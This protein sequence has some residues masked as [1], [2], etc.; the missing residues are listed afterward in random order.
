MTTTYVPTHP[1]YADEAD[2]RNE[3]TRVF[4]VCQSCRRCIGLCSSFPTLFDMIDARDDHDAGWLTPAQ[5]D[6]V[7]DGCVQC[8]LCSLGCPYTPDRDEASVDFPRLMLRAEAMRYENGHAQP[9]TKSAA[10]VI[11]R[12]DLIGRLATAAAPIANRVVTAEPGSL[13]RKLNAAFTGV[14]SQRL[15][16]TFAHRRFSDWFDDRPRI[17]LRRKQGTVT[18][19]PTCLV[20]YQATGIGSDLV[21][22]YERNGI[23]CRLSD[24]GCCGAPWLHAGDVESFTRV[25]EKNVGRLASEIRRGTDVVVPQPTCSYILKNDYVDYVGTE[26]G[27]DAELVAKRTYDAAEYLMRVHRADDT[28]LDTEFAGIIPD[29]ITYHTPCH[30]RAQKIGYPGRDLLRLTGAQVTLVQQCSGVDG[31]WGLRAGND[32]VAIPMAE[33][34]AEMIERADGDVVVSDCHL[35]NTTIAEQTGLTSVHPLQVV[36]HAYGLTQA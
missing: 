12:T 18:V 27:A 21:K 10:K 36:A 31:A 8:K 34:L 22:V 28:V 19:F 29:T 25:A 7:V 24:A 20:E 26:F 17:T 30:L 13:I 1:L 4:D 2:A 35:T 16:P 11:G 9:R 5:Q 32:D 6:H 14:S 33:K 23:E 3:L 15:L